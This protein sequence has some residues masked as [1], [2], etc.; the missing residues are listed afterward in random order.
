MNWE[1][2]KKRERGLKRE[3]GS[4][5]LRRGRGLKRWKAEVSI[6]KQEVAA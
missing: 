4:I 3:R 6:E 1:K 5:S 2:F